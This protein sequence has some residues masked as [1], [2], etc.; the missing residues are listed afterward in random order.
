MVYIIECLACSF[1]ELRLHLESRSV[2][3]LL[4]T[5]SAMLD[6]GKDGLCY[7]CK[8]EV[9]IHQLKFK[10]FQKVINRFPDMPVLKT[11]MT[12]EQVAD[13]QGELLHHNKVLDD[14]GKRNYEKYSS[15]K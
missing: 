7:M 14:E 12:W 3:T 9:K 11:W 10:I 8:G 6:G 4:R 2:S 15:L 5:Q 1:K 13:G